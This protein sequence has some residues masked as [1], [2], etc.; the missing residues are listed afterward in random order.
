MAIMKL[1]YL[2]AVSCETLRIYPIIIFS[3]GRTIA[4]P[5]TI[6]GQEYGVGKSLVAN[7]Y[8]LH[9]REDL[10]PEAQKFKPERFLE[11][12]FSA[13]EFVP[14]GGGNRRCLGAAFAMFEMK[15]VLATI[16]RRYNLALA[17]KGE[18]KPAR[19]G[20]LSGPGGGVKM[21]ML[22]RRQSDRAALAAV[23]AV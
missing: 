10:Y 13:S 9:R 23:S 8:L 18:V 1:P 2:N 17:E 15:L 19:R 4:S 5:I 3:V 16:M 12:Q 22:E 7:I 14:F 20:H 11:R 21:V 6:G